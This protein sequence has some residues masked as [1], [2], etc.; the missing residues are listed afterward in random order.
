MP[1]PTDQI[2]ENVQALEEAQA[3]LEDGIRALLP[4][5]GGY[6]P[7]GE[8]VYRADIEEALENIDRLKAILGPEPAREAL[9]ATVDAIAR[10]TPRHEPYPPK[11]PTNRLFA[12]AEP[13][14]T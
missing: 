1:N 10:Q 13:P 3:T 2:R 4:T 9:W 5:L 8:R 11:C 7:A 6:D 12:D 14:T